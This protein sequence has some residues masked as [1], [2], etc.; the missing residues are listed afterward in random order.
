MSVVKRRGGEN[1]KK[2]KELIEDLKQ[3][4]VE[5]HDKKRMSN[6]STEN[7]I[8]KDMPLFKGCA[9]HSQHLR[10][11]QEEEEYRQELE[12]MRKEREF[13]KEKALALERRIDD[14]LKMNI[15]YMYEECIDD[16]D[17]HVAYASTSLIPSHRHDRND[18][19]H[20]SFS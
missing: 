12:K 10:L 1:S 16:I 8:E 14:R 6:R 15:E 18:A 11:K 2:L 9:L 4:G 5:R 19:A 3:M 7:T 13:W 17:D 20:F